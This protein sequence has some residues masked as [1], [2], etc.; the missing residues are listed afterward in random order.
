MILFD[1]V[2][3][4]VAAAFEM[5][6]DRVTPDADFIEDLGAK[7]V[8]LVDLDLTLEEEF[9]LRLPLDGTDCRTLRA[10]VHYLETNAS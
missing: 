7:S 2:H 6:R 5:E 1:R 3:G 10:L 8:D 4:I 9:G